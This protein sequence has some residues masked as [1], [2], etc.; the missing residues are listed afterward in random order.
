MEQFELSPFKVENYGPCV[1]EDFVPY[2]DEWALISAGRGFR[3]LNFILGV[4]YEFRD[5]LYLSGVEVLQEGEYLRL[6]HYDEW[7]KLV[8]SDGWEGPHQSYY[9]QGYHYY[10]DD[11]PNAKLYCD[12]E[13]L[14]DHWGDIE[15]LGNPWVTNDRIWFEA[16]SKLFPAPEG[17]RIYYATLEGEDITYFCIGANPCVYRDTLYYG[18]WNG[19]S[20]DIARRNVKVDDLL[21]ASMEK[22][23][24]YLRLVYSKMKKYVGKDSIVMEICTRHDRGIIGREVIPH[25]TYIMVDKNPSRPGHTLDAIKDEL[26]SCE[27]L[28]STAILHHTAQEDLVELFRNLGKH[29]KRHIMLS[30]PNVEVLPELFGDHLYHIEVEEMVKIGRAVGWNCIEII[31]CGLS[32]PLCEVLMVFGR[33]GS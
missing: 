6:G 5:K 20:F 9:H 17:W 23:G 25:N 31:P 4:R 29:T 19:T 22:Y 26:P 32:K 33:E 24:E 10:S 30:G 11:A 1:V 21:T 12:G 16:R 2:S 15:E 8:H 7:G 13:I 27:V 28:I 14:I 18:I 3:E